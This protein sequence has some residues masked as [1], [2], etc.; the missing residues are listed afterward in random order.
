MILKFPIS[1]AAICGLVKY[2]E[3]HRFSQKST[4]AGILDIAIAKLFGLRNVI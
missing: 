1:I 2:I 4:G 3:K